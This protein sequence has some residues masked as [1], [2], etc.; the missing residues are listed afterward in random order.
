VNLLLSR[1]LS[2]ERE[3]AVRVAIGAGRREIL[4]Q[5]LTE[6]T[7]L[8][9][10]A[11]AVGLGLASWW[12]KLLRALIGLQL[13][14]WMRVEL[15]GRVLAFTIAV[16]VIA[17][18][19]SGLAPALH[20]SR[21]SLGES[22]KEASRGSSGGGLT[23]RLRDWMIVTGVALAVVLLA[24]AGLLIRGFLELQSQEKGFRSDSL[25]TFRVALGWKRYGG[26]ATNRYYER[27]TEQLLA[28]PG[29]ESVGFIYGP[30]L[31]GLEIS[32]PNTVQAEG[33]SVDEALRNPFVNSQSTSETYFSVMSIP[34]LAGRLFT[35]FDRKDTDQVAIVSE[36]LARL[37][38]PGKSAIGQ[39]L[40]YNPLART[41]TTLRTVVGVVG[42]VQ[43]REL[44]GEA[45]LD[46]YVPFRQSTQANHFMIVKTRLALPEFQRRAEA[47]MW[48]ID[49]E[50]SVFD[51]QTYDQRILAGIWQL[52]ISRLLLVVFGAVALL[53]SAIGIYGVMS[54][55]VGQRTREMGIRLALGA[56][57][58]GVRALIVKRGVLLGSIGLGMGLAGA[59]LLGRL[60]ANTVH[61][62]SS[63]DPMSLAAALTILFGVTALA[64]AVPAWR[65]SRIDPAITLREE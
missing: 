41:P 54:Y 35:P 56:T 57:P 26:D 59:L 46:L 33:Q 45:S 15:D 31:A 17:G 24:G 13:P 10:A 51:F 9:L 14:E 48:A 1:A 64:C 23:G 28:I 27:A 47:A 62:I 30:P 20:L 6:S 22:L 37:L 4:G 42:N 25:A 49:P 34:L 39:W 21:D 7:V 65:A 53:L 11:A 8:A 38:W 63:T 61:G 32:A 16:A 50:Q 58:A 36:R 43:H 60:L 52:R 18:I 29:V 12:M 40:R 2:R 44:S 3:I 19:V 5:L 55:V